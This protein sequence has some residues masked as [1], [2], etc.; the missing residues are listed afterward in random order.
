MVLSPRRLR[1]LEAFGRNF[2]KRGKIEA[3]FEPV[4]RRA[5]KGFASHSFDG[6]YLAS[7]V[8]N[9]GRDAVDHFAEV[10]FVT[11]PFQNK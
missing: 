3:V 10:F 8:C 9:A 1:F 2:K 6:G 7:G 5:L 11:N 4:V